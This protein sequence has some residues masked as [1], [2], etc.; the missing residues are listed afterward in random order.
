MLG[1]RCLALSDAQPLDSLIRQ[2]SDLLEGRKPVS[3]IAVAETGLQTWPDSAQLVMM[4]G[5]SLGQAGR[6]DEGAAELRRATM[7]DPADPETFYNLAVQ[8]YDMGD[9]KEAAVAAREALRMHPAHESAA[10]LLDRCEAEPGQV[11]FDLGKETL[12]PS[13]ASLRTG[14]DSPPASVL[15]LGEAWTRVGYGVFVLCCVSSL[16]L[17]VHPPLVV[18]AQDTILKHDPLS[19]LA[20]FLWPFSGA[21]SIFWTC[22]DLIDRR[23]RF[24]WLL[25]VSSCALVALPALPLALYIFVIRKANVF[26]SA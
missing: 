17:L 7:L 22:V 10:E 24:V 25:P 9:R 1:V 20:I 18:N 13:E 4:Y 14:P 19:V 6:V 5:I 8:L 16:L 12:L 26:R 23:E 3:A 15:K 21:A 11:P 2:I